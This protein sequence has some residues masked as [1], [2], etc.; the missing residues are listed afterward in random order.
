MYR[1]N[2]YKIISKIIWSNIY[3]VIHIT[4][5]N[6]LFLRLYARNLH[7]FVTP[8]KAISGAN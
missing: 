7:L 6:S 1:A 4:A 2:L 5:L 3:S 8:R